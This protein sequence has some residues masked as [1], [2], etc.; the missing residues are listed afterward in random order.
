MAA[1]NGLGALP[2]DRR[3]AYLAAYDL[4]EAVQDVDHAETASTLPAAMALA[5]GR[6]WPEVAAVLAGA[7]VVHEMVRG[8]PATA[9][10]LAQAHVARTER[11][12][13]PALRSVALGLRALQHAAAGEPAALMADA[14]ASVA[15]AES[16]AG[17]P[18][19]RTTGFVVAAAALNTLQ[20][21]E[22]VEE[23]FGLAARLLDACERP[24][25]A[26]AIRPNLVLTRF[27]HS[28]AL[29]E[30]GDEVRALA[31]LTGIPTLLEAAL[32]ENLPDLWR[33]AMVV[34]GDV[35]ALLV[36]VL[37]N[38]NQPLGPLLDAVSAGCRRLREVG[39]VEV[40]PMAQ[41]VLVLAQWRSGERAAALH[42]AA[43]LVDPTSVS[44]ASASFP[45][46]VRAQVLAAAEPGPA[47]DAVA[48]HAQVLSRLRARSRTAVLAAARGALELERSRGEHARTV[49][50]AR[51]DPLTG[52]LNRREFEAW[53]QD[54]GPLEPGTSLLLLDLDHFKQV[55]DTWGH[56]VGDEALRRVGA[57]VRAAVRTG[58]RA[59]RIGG[60]EIAVLLQVPADAPERAHQRA[61]QLLDAIAGQHWSDLGAGVRVSC[62]VGVAG[63]QG[64][65]E[66]R[67]VELYRLADHDLYVAKRSRRIP[68]HARLG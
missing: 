28:L 52:L 7:E 53:L 22:L 9:R 49:E 4:F 34:A 3:Q 39:D 16:D 23:L 29:V 42:G 43:D 59:M 36:A 14:A 47:M 64:A 15:L 25:M 51:T 31:L 12:G 56:D 46:W 41:A 62:T 68:R 58:D 38:G 35:A 40:R 48:E 24:A 63:V 66:R 27:E 65:Q 50:A 45:L 19:D 54:A 37:G 60:D 26:A 21:W 2:T 1:T 44:S 10:R 17:D 55:N 11:L 33:E 67:P 30:Q 20:A 13:D 6:G 32:A 61:E 18:I 5:E 8:E 57:I